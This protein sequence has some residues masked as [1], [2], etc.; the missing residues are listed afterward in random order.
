MH[1][2]GSC[3]L[4]LKFVGFMLLIPKSDAARKFPYIGA[5][6][7]IVSVSILKASII[8]VSTL[9]VERVENRRFSCW[10]TKHFS[11]IWIENDFDERIMPEFYERTSIRGVNLKSKC[12]YISI[13]Q[14][15]VLL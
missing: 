15:T 4:A 12:I 7:L 3:V 10:Y 8:V 9:N 1:D 14:I 13:L 11:I 5:L 6:E 2:H